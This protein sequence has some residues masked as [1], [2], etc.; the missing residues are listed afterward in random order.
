MQFLQMK[1]DKRVSTISTFIKIVLLFLVRTTRQEKEMKWIQIG[2]EEVKLS[3][4]LDNMIPFLKDPNTLP[5]NS[6]IW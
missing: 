2:K 3:L 6:Y 4:I 5:E 1:N